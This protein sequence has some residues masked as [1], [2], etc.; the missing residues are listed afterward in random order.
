MPSL[1]RRRLLLAS[2]IVLSVGIPALA[3]GGPG[4][5][6]AK[7]AHQIIGQ[8][9][10]RCKGG[11]RVQVTQMPDTARVDF[12]GR[13]QVLKLAPEGSGVAYQNNNFAWFSQGKTSYMKNTHSGGLALTDCVALGN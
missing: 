5:T 10:Y 1:P 11:I 4:A 2:L 13:S 9:R 8:S 12:A 3:S 6:S 7:D